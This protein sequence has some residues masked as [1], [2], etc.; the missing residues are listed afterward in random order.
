MSEPLAR[1]QKDVPAAEGF[2]D[3][4]SVRRK[5]QASNTIHQA[6]PD[7]IGCLCPASGP[8]CGTHPSYSVI[9]ENGIRINE[10]AADTAQGHRPECKVDEAFFPK[11][12]AGENGETG[13]DQSEKIENA[14]L[15]ISAAQCQKAL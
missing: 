14:P 5:G 10:T 12:P 3:R 13:A 7:Q 1:R 9:P 4:Q 8:V 2:C 15:P 6:A 11:Q